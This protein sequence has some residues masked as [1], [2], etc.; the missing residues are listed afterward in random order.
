MRILVTGGAGYVGSTT[1]Q[2]LIEAGHE[3]V[4]YDSLELGH[5]AAVPEGAVLV[6]GYIGDQGLVEA[7]LREHSID[8]VLHCAG[9]SLVGESVQQPQRY[10]ENNVARG[11]AFL[12]SL[13]AAGV[14][15]VVFSSSAAVY[16]VPDRIPIEETDTLAPV[17]PYG[18]TKLALENALTSYATAYEWRVVSVRYFNAAGA[19]DKLGEDHRPETHLIPNI[20]AA[21]E[22]GHTVRIF[23]SDYPT[24]D[25]TCVRDYIH[26]DDLA[27]AHIA[28]LE[29]T[30]T[31][32]AGHLACNL[33]SGS[34]FSN[35]EILRAAE[36]VVGHAIPHEIVERRPGDPPALVASNGRAREMLGWE[37]R[38]GSLEEV[39]GSAWA[40]RQ[41]HPEGY[42]D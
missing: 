16:G 29:L 4:A 39:I 26:V 17:N 24:P 5:R 11:I 33:G 32:D 20:L 22:R 21:V 7:T 19:T 15:R 38:H 42:T 2:R 3:V 9:Y 6:S 34:G 8:A 36:Q 1:A 13:L 37:P 35:L 41:R 25:G 18:A 14:R 30:A 31:R 40:W 28:A 10:F 12:D 27:A 23:G